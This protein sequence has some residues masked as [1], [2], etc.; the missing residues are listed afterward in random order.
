ML[1]LD[2]R[3]RDWGDLSFPKC[4]YYNVSTIERYYFHRLQVPRSMVLH[5]QSF[6]YHLLSPGTFLEDNQT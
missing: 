4:P 1:L 6:S 5:W 2:K 3:G